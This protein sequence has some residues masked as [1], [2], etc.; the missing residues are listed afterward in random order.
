MG[1]VVSGSSSNESLLDSSFQLLAPT[2]LKGFS[3][4]P[5]LASNNNNNSTGNINGNGSSNSNNFV[6][7]IA[8]TPSA[9]NKSIINTNSITNSNS[10]SK[11]RSSSILLSNNN[12]GADSNF[13]ITPILTPS[14]SLLFNNN[15][16]TNNNNNDTQSL[17]SLPASSNINNYCITASAPSSI[18]EQLRRTPMNKTPLYASTGSISNNISLIDL[19][20]GVMTPRPNSIAPS[21]ERSNSA[22][23]SRSNSSVSEHL[24]GSSSLNGPI[25]ISPKFLDLL[26]KN[27]QEIVADP[28]ITPFDPSN[29]PP[30][31][32]TKVTKLS[33]K[34]A[35]NKKLDT[36]LTN[37][38]SVNQISNISLISIN[39]TLLKEVRKDGYFSRN[40]S[41][42]SFSIPLSFNLNNNN[43]NNSNNTDNVSPLIS[44]SLTPLKLSNN[45]P[46]DHFS[47]QQYLFP[48]PTTI[49][50]LN[51]ANDSNPATPTIIRQPIP[52]NIT[53]DLLSCNNNTDTQANSNKSSSE[54]SSLEQPPSFIFD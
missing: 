14:N 32:L 28:T 8:T 52:K 46:I 37:F 23:S 19:Y 5:Y 54:Q 39:N 35:I 45:I 53:N 2:P 27:Y 51:T 44:T 47:N 13:N 16:C 26:L 40:N 48:T 41:V 4:L 31:I 34:M 9:I 22:F 10:R 33:L 7:S 43:L 25:T 21:L 20:S 49:T 18:N 11:S 24:N 3:G 38:N 12:L 15:N 29:P 36:G 30:N 1:S 17:S 50:T 42:C 6:I